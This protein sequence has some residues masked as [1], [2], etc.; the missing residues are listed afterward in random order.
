M[1]VPQLQTLPA[2]MDSS[3]TPL[4]DTTPASITYWK[5]RRNA[6][7]YFALTPVFDTTSQKCVRIDYCVKKRE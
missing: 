1:D 6:N 5:T 3:L 4:F 2:A 7:L